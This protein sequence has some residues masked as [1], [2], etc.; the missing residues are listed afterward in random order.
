M[1]WLDWLRPSLTD[2]SEDE[3]LADLEAGRARLWLGDGCALVTQYVQEPEGACLHIWLAGGA[4]AGV[5]A[6]RPGVEAWA[7]G[8]GCQSI[9]IEGRP[10]WRRVLRPYGYRPAGR[11][12]KRIL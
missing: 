1:T 3:L 8:A 2:A 7:K 10:G 4:L 9:T 5:L 11:E 6:L 12:L